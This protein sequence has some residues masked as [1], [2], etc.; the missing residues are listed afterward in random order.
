M[1][2]PRSLRTRLDETLTL[3][4]SRQLVL[5]HAPDPRS[6]RVVAQPSGQS[7]IKASRQLVLLV[8]VYPI[9]H[10]STKHQ[11]QSYASQAFVMSLK[12]GTATGSRSSSLSLSSKEGLLVEDLFRLVQED[13][14]ATESQDVDKK[15]SDLL[16]Q[17]EGY[18]VAPP[19]NER[20]ALY[21][22]G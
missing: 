6:K 7:P 21:I 15:V 2:T 3:F 8:P 16:Q 14:P 1:I 11:V 19:S 4:H 20:V 10:G 22:G 12:L 18:F 13:T 5:T 17:L 9:I